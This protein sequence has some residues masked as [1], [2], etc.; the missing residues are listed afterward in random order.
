MTVNLFSVY[1]RTLR[2]VV[3]IKALSQFSWRY[4][5]TLYL[6]K[7][8]FH[9]YIF[10]PFSSSDQN[11]VCIS[12]LPH[13]CNVPC[14]FNWTWSSDINEI[15]ERFKI[16]LLIVQFSPSVCYFILLLY[17]LV[18]KS[19]PKWCQALWQIGR[20]WEHALIRMG[21]LISRHTVDVLK[22]VTGFCSWL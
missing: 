16:M 2:I 14:T 17:S 10:T 7:I 11:L 20:V 1:K 5:L 21:N 8:H 15:S 18:S 3:F 13:A 19:K 6:F 12:Y 9:I 4:N 22:S